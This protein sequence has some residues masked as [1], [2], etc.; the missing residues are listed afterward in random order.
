M[1]TMSAQ[2]VTLPN[3]RPGF[4]ALLVSE[5]T[6][7]RSVRSTL[8]SLVLLVVISV[9]FTALLVA[10]TVGQWSKSDASDHARIALDPVG[11]ILGAGLY[12][13]QLTIC[14]MGVMVMAS[15][16]STGMIRASLLAVPKRIPMLVAKCIVFAALVLVIGEVVTFTSFAVGAPILSS[17]VH[18]SLGQSGALRAVIG[19]GLYLAMLGLFSL[20]IGGIVR[21]T[22]VGITGTIAFVLVIAPLTQLLPG[23][24]GKHVHAYLPTVAGQLIGHSHRVKDDL[25]G[26]W[27]G[28][29]VF[30]IWTAV[31][32][33]IAAV[34]L[35]RRD[36]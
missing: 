12:F 30:A 11:T 16:Y 28:Y 35:S 26:P 3:T 5:W 32:L 24:V 6:K 27:A 10:L 25:M 21:N 1:T 8:W 13:G 2:P 31:L 14:V 22:A 17:K 23:S 36:A 19:G 4:G 18:V 7:I 20:A 29:G 34:L 33:V 9:G 15:E